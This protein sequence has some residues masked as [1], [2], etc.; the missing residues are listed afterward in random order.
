MALGG[1]AIVV[2]LLPGAAGAG[3]GFRGKIVK[4]RVG[5]QPV[6]GKPS[7][8]RYWDGEAS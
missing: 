6:G 8:V 4:E 5:R 3:H 1:L 2:I 7:G